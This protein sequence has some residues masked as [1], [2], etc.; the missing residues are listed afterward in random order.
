MHRST[1]S[2]KCMD[3]ICFTLKEASH[4]KGKNLRKWKF[5]EQGT[6]HFFS[7]KHNSYGRFMSLVSLNRGGR[8]VLIIPEIALNAGWKEI[9]FKIERFIKS[10]K[11]IT[12]NDPPRFTEVNYPYSSAVQESKWHTKTLHKADGTSRKG[13]ITISKVDEGQENELLKRSLVG[14]FGLGLKESPTLSEVRKWSV[15]AWKKAFGVNIYEMNGEMFLFEFPNRFMAETILQGQWLWNNQKVQL[16]WWSRT[17]GCIPN[18]SKVTKTWIKAVGVPLHLWS[19]K[20][21]RE[22]GEFCGGWV[23]T[24]EESELKN[25]LKW[26]RILVENDG[27]SLPREVVITQGGITYY[28][29]IWPESKARFEISPEVEEEVAGEEDAG[30]FPVNV[31]TQ[32]IKEKSFCKKVQV[33]PFSRDSVDITHMGEKCLTTGGQIRVHAHEEHMP[34]LSDEI[35]VGQGLMLGQQLEPKKGK[36]YSGQIGPDLAGHVIF[37]DLQGNQNTHVGFDQFFEV[38]VNTVDLEQTHAQL[39]LTNSTNAWDKAISNLVE[40]VQGGT[41]QGISVMEKAREENSNGTLEIESRIVDSGQKSMIPAEILEIEEAVP[42]HIRQEQAIIEEERETS[43]WVQQNMIKLSKL[44]GIDFQ[45]HEE[46]ALELLLQVDSCRQARRME[47]VGIS[48]R[49][50]CKGVQELKSL[51]TFDV[52]FKDSGCRNKGRK[53]LNSDPCNSN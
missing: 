38:L 33:S 24:E 1:M 9:A 3:W 16:K 23:A 18:S 40:A 15:S 44:L 5:T 36:V 53:L 20:T 8:D 39:Q 41:P 50:R 26:A 22:I 6:E 10:S 11:S 42:L 21:F 52:K 49:S 13:D 34:F 43:A 28:I 32:Q 46:E 27:R 35:N 37:N 7:R 25:H 47:S 29:P 17:V 31:M 19:Q 12:L 30:L 4:D 48:K 2:S 45:G 14:S 51:V